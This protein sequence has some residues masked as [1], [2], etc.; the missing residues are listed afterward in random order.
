MS[1]KI[2][3]REQTD[4]FF[5]Q[6][7]DRMSLPA[8]IMKLMTTPF[9]EVRVEVPIQR[10][11]GTVATFIGYRV[12]HSN[13]RGPMKGGLRYHPSVEIEEVR[14][15]A[16]LMT[17]KTAVVD[18]PFGGGKGGIDCDTT[19]LSQEEIERLTRKYV[20]RLHEIIGPN[21]DIP[22]PDVCTNPQVMAWFMDQ[23]S[24]YHGFTPACVTGKPLELYGSEGRNEATG[25]GVV[26]AAQSV[27]RDLGLPL[28]GARVVIQGFG[29]VG[30]FAA[31]YFHEA[32]AKVTAV[33]DVSAA[34]RNPEG[35]DIPGLLAYIQKNGLIRGWP[36]GESFDKDQ[37]LTEPCEILA[38]AAL[39]HVLTEDNARDVQAQLVIEAA[40]GPITPRADEILNQRGI[41]ILPDIYAN[42]GGVTVSYFEWVQNLQQFRW[43]LEK[44][45]EELNRT[46]LKSYAALKRVA[47][48]KK[49]SLRTAAF[50]LAISRVGKTRALRG[51]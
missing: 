11:D 51:L 27:A 49:V 50:V 44:V 1:E 14:S 18:I 42:A 46:M 47:E 40:N 2:S 20:D 36:G 10:D 24:Q 12:Q 23:F 35:L 5:R 25:R 4:Y 30:S 15:L 38:P 31:K 13:A 39:G 8:S 22:A 33:S 34:L 26:I 43:S 28:K 6:A 3:P 17:W 32:G 16:S 19:Q 45:N 37:L 21:K 29:N 7:A 48:E 9:R 41:A